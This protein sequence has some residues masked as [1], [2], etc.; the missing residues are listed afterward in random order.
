MKI[1]G[2]CHF[3]GR[4]IDTIA[5]TMVGVV[6]NDVSKKAH[7][8]CHL[9]HIASVR[10]DKIAELSKQVQD[11]EDEIWAKD[12]PFES[13]PWVTDI[14]THVPAKGLIGRAIHW[15]LWRC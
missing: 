1:E 13:H 14:P 4:P 15:L 9:R 8:V 10:L 2:T 5:G 12:H 7:E 11:L 3:C 6:F